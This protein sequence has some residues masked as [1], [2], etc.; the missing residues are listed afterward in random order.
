[1]P[2]TTAL[3]EP[4]TSAGVARAIHPLEHWVERLTDALAGREVAAL[5]DLFETESTVRDLLALSWDF[6]NAVGREDVVALL[7]AAETEAP[8]HIGIR[9]DATNHLFPDADDPSLTA[10]IEFTTRQGAGEGYVRLM[11]GDDGNWRAVTLLLSLSAIDGFIEQVGDDRPMGRVHGP[12]RNREG[13][14]DSQDPEFERD[15]PAVVILG[16]GHNG[17]ILAA[18]LRALGISVLVLESNPRVGDNWR[19]RYASLALHTPLIADQLPYLPFP[20]TWTRFTPKD[21]LGDFLESYATLLDLPVWTSAKV[22]SVQ[23]DEA[24]DRWDV[25][26]KRADGTRRRLRP[27]HFVFATGMNGAPKLPAVPGNDQF[28][29][30]VIHA[31]DYQGFEP[32]AGKKVVVVGCGV[33]G[34]DIAQDLAE[35]GV[36]VTMVQRSGAV[37]LSTKAF[38]EVMHATHTSGKYSLAEGDLINAAVPFGALPAYG[39]EQLRA[40]REID[41]EMLSGLEE[42]GFLLSEGPD[43]EGVLGLIFRLNTTG[44]YYNA[45]ASDL[46]IDGS[47][48]LRHGGVAGLTDSGVLLDDGS[49]VDADLVVFATGYEPPTAAARQLLGDEIANQLG[50]FASVGDDGEYGSLWRRTGVEGLWFMVALSIEHGR[51]YSKHLALQIAAA[52]AGITAAS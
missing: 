19:R 8:L 5:A 29:G 33:S 6:R 36:D 18:R 37:V 41:E 52:E 22:K 7:T 44:Y 17:L 21:K 46:I 24:A 23:Y 28:Q 51:F 31:V 40:A 10:F 11:H 45:G 9:H 26:V 2:N 35:H 47:I 16:A 34:H 1:M 3:P 42:A 43:G 32:W 27:R 13:W 15:D 48:K 20:S 4:E 50:E 12:I 49:T 38:H 25:T 30:K 14:R 39:A